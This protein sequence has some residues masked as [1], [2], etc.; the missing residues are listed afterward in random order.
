MSY[1]ETSVAAKSGGRQTACERQPAVGRSALGPER[2]AAAPDFLGVADGSYAPFIP[3]SK[4]KN[5][6]LDGL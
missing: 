3:R 1:L 6:E 4:P 5:G 2:N